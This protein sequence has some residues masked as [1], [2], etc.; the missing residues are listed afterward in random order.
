MLARLLLAVALFAQSASPAFEAASIKRNAS[1]DT[2]NRFETA[3]G[4]VNAV[5]VPV[6]FVIRQAYRLP[7]SRIVGGPAWIRTDRFDIVAKAP[8]GTTGWDSL[9]A[10]MRTLLADRFA[11]VTHSDA[12]EMPVYSL[13]RMRPDRLGPGLR[14]SSSDCAGKPPRAVGGRVQ[15][16]IMVSQNAA[17]GSLR[18]GGTPFSEF[19]ARLADFLDR[20]LIDDTGLSGTPATFDLELQF[21]AE[22]SVFPGAPVPGGLDAAPAGDEI[23]SVFTAL[24]EQM[25]LTLDARQGRAE[26]LVVDRVERPSEN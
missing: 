25:G 19:V 22:R 21:T 10:M 4:R 13:R 18:G 1:K 14:P 17:S 5:N 2:R 11:L 15:C 9:F 7:E 8:T 20:P 3:P 26:V 6:L 24:R 12:R 16:G 23:P